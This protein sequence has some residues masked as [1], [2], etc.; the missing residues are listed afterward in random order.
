MGDY[1]QLE[2][3]VEMSRGGVVGELEI[4]SSGKCWGEN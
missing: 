3:P 2:L 1:E 4:D